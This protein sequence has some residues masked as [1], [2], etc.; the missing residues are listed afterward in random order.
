MRKTVDTDKDGVFERGVYGAVY[1]KAGR[2]GPTVVARHARLTDPAST[3][4]YARN[5]SHGIKL[6]FGD[7]AEHDVAT[8]DGFQ[9]PPA[10]TGLE[11]QPLFGKD[12]TFSRGFGFRLV[13]VDARAADATDDRFEPAVDK[14][15]LLARYESAFHL[16]EDSFGGFKDLD[17]HTEKEHPILA[18]EQPASHFPATAEKEDLLSNLKIEDSLEWHVGLT[19][20]HDALVPGRRVEEDGDARG[21]NERDD[22]L[23]IFLNEWNT[24]ADQYFEALN[25]V[26]DGRNISALPVLDLG[27][28]RGCGTGRDVDLDRKLLWVLFGRLIDREPRARRVE[29]RT[30]AQTVQGAFN[31]LCPLPVLSFRMNIWKYKPTIVTKLKSIRFCAL[32]NH[33][34][35]SL[36]LG[37]AEILKPHSR[38]PDFDDGQFDPDPLQIS[39]EYRPP[40]GQWDCRFLLALTG[41]SDA[42]EDAVRLGSLDFAL[43]SSTTR[44][45]LADVRF[46][47]EDRDPLDRS[48]PPRADPR[49]S[50]HRVALRVQL[51][52]MSV[53]QA[54]EDL[55][56][57]NVG[58]DADDFTARPLIDPPDPDRSILVPLADLRTSPPNASDSDNSDVE[59]IEQ[60][61]Q[62]SVAAVSEPALLLN[63]V[64]RAGEESSRTFEIEMLAIADAASASGVD[65]ETP[66]GAD[67][68]GSQ[69]PDLLYISRAP[70]LIAA[71]QRFSPTQ[72]LGSR[73]DNRVGQWRY[74]DGVGRWVLLSPGQ[75]A[76]VLLPTQAVGESM[77][78]DRGNET[79]PGDFADNDRADFRFGPLTELVIDPSR[80]DTEVGE[81]PLNLKRLLLDSDN[82]AGAGLYR[83]AFELLYGMTARLS[84]VAPAANVA[85]LRVA[86]RLAREGR[87]APQLPSS[88]QQEYFERWSRTACGTGVTRRDARRFGRLVREKA[89]P[90]K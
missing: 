45:L 39:L 73:T 44:R 52:G 4:K 76:R 17:W 25:R 83:A 90:L 13:T 47:L 27:G 43:A 72:A 6:Q 82:L 87:F 60:E 33:D 41:Q 50:V 18:L 48:D 3:K 59:Q 69:Q 21:P 16:V 37:P 62:E 63:F 86:D 49:P 36:T 67:W 20:L 79:G 29:L 74:E 12:R 38:G 24:A 11:L 28:E 46:A 66:S 5:K 65:V 71:G 70:F 9:K 26:D 75:R 77:E 22:T 58:T 35:D 8:E 88:G 10:L 56:G 55:A 32:R 64:E 57:R 85:P 2:R 53:M 14:P 40:N 30:A 89:V 7:V 84:P 1:N 81:Q 61:K 54:A 51:P 34:G 42:T 23:K 80:Q 31:A 15:L 78:R 68:Y 19:D